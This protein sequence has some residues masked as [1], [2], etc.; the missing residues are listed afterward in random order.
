[1]V[2]E[3]G[4]GVEAAL[5][6]ALQALQERSELLNRVA[7][8]MDDRAPQSRARFRQGAQDADERAAL[9]RRVLTMGNALREQIG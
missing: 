7:D 4:E 2:E 9:I 8:R 6:A 3:Q 1:M 5:W